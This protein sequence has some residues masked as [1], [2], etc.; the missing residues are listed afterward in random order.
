MSLSASTQQGNMAIPLV[1]SPGSTHAKVQP[2]NRKWL[3][4]EPP[5][6]HAMSNQQYITAVNPMQE[7]EREREAET[8]PM[9]M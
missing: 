1:T 3:C 8:E 6:D 9:S 4:A 7:L 2:E 5:R